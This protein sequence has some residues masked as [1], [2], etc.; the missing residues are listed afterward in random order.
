MQRANATAL[1]AV[2]MGIW[3]SA[4]AAP[5]RELTFEQTLALA[6]E[7]APAVVAARASIDEARGRA[8]GAA[9]LLRDN[10]VVDG[11]AGSRFKAD[12][13]QSLE[14]RLGVGQVFEVGGQRAA[15]ISGADANLAS[16]QAA[17]DNAL[18]LALRAVAIGFYRGLHAAE[19]LRL[20][21]E[22]DAVAADTLRIAER[23]FENG[24]A[25]RLDVGLAQ[26]ARARSTASVHD[27]DATH[28][29]A[30]GA[31]RALLDLPGDEPLALHG[32]LAAPPVEPTRAIDRPDLR[33]LE[34]DID[35]AQAD[36]RLGA[37]SRWP[38]L[39]LG[40]EYERD[41]NDDL[42]LGRLSLTLPVFDH[43]QGQR[44]EAVARQTRLRGELEAARRVAI[45]ELGAAERVYRSRAAAAVALR[46]AVP[47]QDENARMAQRA[48]QTGE[49]GLVD[50][51]A[52]RRE[53]LGTR[54]DALDRAFE[55][56][57]AAIDLEFTAGTLK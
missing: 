18:R 21:R 42:A 48:Y 13:D 5:A 41:E 26:A 50:L 22:A 54:Q 30:L 10:P 53:V 23:R 1:L 15:R 19:S 52:V 51:L 34:A 44:A 9:V 27:A 2:V 39:G 31:L 45:A 33:A 4:N 6:R 49:L 7:R 3:V 36:E 38:D 11:A 8:V 16:A 17:A 35:A 25:S 40:A 47:Q 43:G 32:E 46:D 29:A 20:A 57:A 28:E 12:G 37:A 14:A 24:D 56:A 55:A